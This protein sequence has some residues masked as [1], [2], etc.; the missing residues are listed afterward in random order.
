MR[1]LFQ[2]ENVNK[3]TEIVKKKR[4]KI[5]SLNS[6]ITEMREKFMRRTK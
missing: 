5:W 2:I 4:V 6:S 3:Q 1:M